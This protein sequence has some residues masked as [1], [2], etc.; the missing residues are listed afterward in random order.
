ML[1]GFKGLSVNDG[2]PEGEGVG[3]FKVVPEAQAAG[4]GAHA[5]AAGGDLPI[6]IEGGGFPFHVSAEGEDELRPG[7]I[8]QRLDTLDQLFDGEV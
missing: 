7:G 8:L 2:A 4:E 6:Q 1:S 5:D 3:V